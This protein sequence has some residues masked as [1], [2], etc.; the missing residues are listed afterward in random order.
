MDQ[1]FITIYY[2]TFKVYGARIDMVA[3]GNDEESYRR[4]L[5][6]VTKKG[7]RIEISFKDLKFE[8]ALKDILQQLTQ[9]ITSKIILTIVGY[10]PFEFGSEQMKVADSAREPARG[11]NLRE[12]VEPRLLELGG[13]H[14]IEYITDAMA[15]ACAGFWEG[16]VPSKDESRSYTTA[17]IIGG[18]GIGGAVVQRYGRVIGLAH[19][20]EFG[21]IRIHIDKD[22]R[23]PRSI[24]TDH[25]GCLQGVASWAALEARAKR[26]GFDTLT[27][28]FKDP[29]HVLWTVQ[30]RYFS[31]AVQNLMFTTPP[32]KIVVA[33]SMFELAPWLIGKIM[34][35]LRSEDGIGSK[36]L[37]PAAQ[38]DDFIVYKS[39]TDEA[40][41]GGIHHGL[42]WAQSRPTAWRREV[43]A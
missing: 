25:G 36:F 22:D 1:H 10:G 27:P 30:A 29:E 38:K 23:Y 4:Q 5:E 6:P 32:Y 21:H 40:L 17:S 28:L 41:L 12:I 7:R 19:H 16:Y 14:Q 24:C 31:Q 37:Y 3:P 33:G 35:D 13:D 9:D 39:L 8:D 2:E 20:S 15:V 26:Y 34:D 43:V 42:G 11:H 18:A